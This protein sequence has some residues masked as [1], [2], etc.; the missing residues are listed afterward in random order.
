MYPG[1]RRMSPLPTL[2]V[3]TIGTISKPADTN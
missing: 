1:Q 3:M 2:Q